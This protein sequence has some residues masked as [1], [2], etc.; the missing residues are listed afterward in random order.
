MAKSASDFTA[1]IWA[2]HGKSR[3]GSW[4][5]GCVYKKYTEAELVLPITKAVDAALKRC[6]FNTITDAAGNKLNM[7][8]Q[9]EQ[10]NAKD[11][12]IHLS[13]HL[14]WS[15]APKG[16]YPI[17]TSNEGEKPAIGLMLL[18]HLRANPSE[19]PAIEP[20]ILTLYV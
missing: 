18:D 20:C 7:I 4:D 2:G 19:I 1:A 11:A 17:C 9:V 13:I 8:E 16:T 6:G 10:S 15:G 3:D 5:P 12:D 14:E